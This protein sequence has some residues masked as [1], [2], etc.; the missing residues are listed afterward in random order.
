MKILQNVRKVPGGMIVVPLIIG[1]IINTF[2]PQ[3]IGI[4]GFT[5]ALGN[6]GFATLCAANMFCVGTKLTLRGA[7]KILKKGFSIMFA[8][9]GIASLIG[10]AIAKFFNGSLLGLSTLAVLAAMN[11]TNG[12]M[13]LALTTEMG[14]EEDCATTVVQS[15]ETGPFLTMLV[16]SGTGLAKIPYMAMVA[17]L[18]PIIVGAVLGNVD[19][20]VRDFCSKHQEVIIPFLGFALGD[21]INLKN[22][23]H[24]GGSG[25]LLGILTVVFTGI[26]CILADVLTGGSGV[27]GA[28]AS[29]TAGNAA[30][31]PAAVAMSD[32][33]YAA[34]SPVATLQVAASIIVTSILTPI[35]TTF[36]YKR[37]KRKE[38][39]QSH[40][41]S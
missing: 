1:A 22:L 23:V 30:A 12:G 9:V 14:T 13:F 28:A 26:A 21:G 10:L 24:A 15:V 2:I 11:D 16:L 5:E 29:T 38:L 7:P 33:S 18:V 20:E 32:H 37:N 8:K 31:T 41:V 36:I 19:K 3:V 34:V 4:G 6:K 39:E 25:L 40:Q 27:A 17:V 35:L